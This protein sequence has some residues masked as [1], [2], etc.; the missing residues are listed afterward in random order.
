MKGFL[1]RIST[2]P[3][4]LI[5]VGLLSLAG[6]AVAIYTSANGPWGAQDA[7]TYIITAR[8]L[9]RGI[10]LGYYLPT[11]QFVT[12]TIKP[13]LFSAILGVLGLTGFNL[14][15]AARWLNILLFITTILLLGLIFLRFSSAAWLS[16]PAC[17]VLVFFPTTVRM[18]SS[19]LSEPLFVFLL[20]ATIYCLLAYLRFDRQRWLAL[21]A[22][23]AGLLSMT[24]Y[25]GLAIILVGAAGIFLFQAG[26]WIKRLGKALLFSLLASLPFLIW[27]A[28]IFFAVDHSFAGRGIQLDPGAVSGNFIRYYSAVTQYVLSWI[29][30]GISIWNLPFRYRY[31]LIFL[32]IIVV[33]VLVFFAV[34]K[35]NRGLVPSLRDTDFQLFGLCGFWLAAYLL[36]LAIDALTLTPNPPITNRIMLP[37]FAGLVPGFFAAMA[38][39]QKAWFRGK[40]VWLNILPWGVALWAAIWYAPTTITQVAIPL[41]AGQGQ[42][43]Y[44]WRSSETMAAVR[45][46]PKDVVV[47]SNDGYAIWVWAD[48]PAYD[49]NDTIKSTFIDQ[50][51]PYGTDRTDPAQVAFSHQDAV[52]VIFTAELPQ[53]LENAFGSRGTDRLATLFTGLVVSQKFSDGIIYS[54]PK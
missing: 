53:Q 50:T 43:A 39:W 14:V 9:M 33:I 37:F 18:Y 27:E 44:T 47:V 40:L 6:G 28:W 1:N 32:A 8:N 54:Y 48:R 4:L 10:G 17:L 52:L 42:T 3:V 35:T 36:F 34:R 23:A 22:V 21:S 51:S 41:H 11:G 45:G 12:W 7:A 38:A 46:L 13:P 30:F 24:R 31:S 49:I 5:A 25:I 15:A 29:P 19:A 26:P 2:R 16:I 20:L